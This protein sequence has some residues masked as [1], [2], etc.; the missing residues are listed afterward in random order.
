MYDELL[1]FAL[2]ATPLELEL[3][4]PRIDFGGRKWRHDES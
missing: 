3:E 1:L 4:P 2:D